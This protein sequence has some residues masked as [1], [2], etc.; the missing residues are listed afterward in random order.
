M[1]HIFYP[2]ELE[3]SALS[4]SYKISRKKCGKQYFV[5]IFKKFCFSSWRTVKKIF[6]PNSKKKQKITF[7]FV[8]LAM[9]FFLILFFVVN[10]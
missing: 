6:F 10:F 9:L 5:D 4:L 7:L 3:M 1:F 2:E 8:F